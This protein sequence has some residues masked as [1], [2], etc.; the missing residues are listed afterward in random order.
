MAFTR[1]Y[2]ITTPAG[3]E[4]VSSGDDRIRAFKADIEERLEN[5]FYG[6]NADST[7]GDEATA[8][9]KALNFK[10][11]SSISTPSADQISLAAKE[12][13]GKAELHVK[14]EDGDEF[15]I[16]TGGKIGGSN[17][18]LTAGK[19]LTG[20]STSDIALN[21]DKFTVAG[22]TG[23]VSVGGTLESV[24]VATLA[25][26]S[27][28]KTTAAPAAD[29][30]IANK[31]YVDNAIGQSSKA[32]GTSDISN[33]SADWA[34][35][36]NMSVALTTKGGNV[37]LLFT[38]TI[39]GSQALSA[40]SLRFYDGSG[41]VG[42]VYQS[43]SASSHADAYRPFSMQYLVT[44]LAAGAY[45]FKVQWKDTEGTVY[46]DGASYPRTLIAIELPS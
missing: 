27:V 2:E 25:D 9:A 7:T 22:A 23:N 42:T 8:G 38:G 36:T 37:L 28:T 44:S 21:T 6:F 12:A 34:D 26:T 43:E 32:T 4:D 35:M 39:R 15:Q 18:D 5:M 29:A 20:S 10:E 33:T 1:D 19:D 24:G 30:Q 16:T 17:I 31:L 3:T 41:A 45:T 13:G 14:D 46:Q 11:Q 40:W